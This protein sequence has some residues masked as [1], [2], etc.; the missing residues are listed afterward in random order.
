[1]SCARCACREQQRGNGNFLNKRTVEI[2]V[3]WSAGPVVVIGVVGVV[4]RR[5][6]RLVLEAS[7]DARAGADIAVCVGN[8]SKKTN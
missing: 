1:M 3:C 6:R 7:R 8:V 5:R 4:L 2:P